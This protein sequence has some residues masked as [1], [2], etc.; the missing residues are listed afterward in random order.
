MLYDNAL[1]AGIYL[2]VFTAT[3]EPWY[4]EVT[5]STL[6]YV[7]KTMTDPEGGFYSAEDADSEGVEGKFYVWTQ[8]E[9]LEALG[10]ALGSRFCEVYDISKEGNFEDK[11]IPNL[12]RSLTQISKI[13]G[14]DLDELTQ[15]MATARA[16][17][18][19]I[20]AQRIRPL[21][22]DKVLVSW[23]ALM[24]DAMARSG[25]VFNEQRYLEAATTAADFILSTLRLKDGRLR[26]MW[27]QGRG[28][29][30]GFLDDYA[31]LINA[32]ITLYESTFEERWIE[33]ALELVAKMRALFADS[34][35]GGFYFTSD[36]HQ[37][38]F[39]RQTDLMDSS[40]PSGNG[41][42]ATALVRLGKLCGRVDF[43]E[44]ARDIVLRASGLLEQSPMAAGQL[45]IAL[46]LLVGPVT[47]IAILGNR[48]DQNTNF[49]I[50][51]LRS[52]FIPNKV[53][54]FRD[55]VDPLESCHALDPI[56]LGRRMGLVP[57]TVFLCEKFVCQ[58]PIQGKKLALEAWERLQ[59]SP[60]TV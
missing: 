60:P 48:D 54:A 52:R 24:I 59:Q 53:V 36:E 20:R 41:M 8:V 10:S 49:V 5:K 34:E 40:V 58:A 37:Q 6:D 17:L 44:M 38:L 27:R 46:D 32:L 57:P 1:L 15:E 3:N 31:Y 7:L 22:D 28:S 51:A 4:A 2:D 16:L 29:G 11:N 47:E 56:F 50:D 12:P 13:K 45:L 9:I 21:L 25:A 35:R 33:S 19:E 30:D 39:S 18:R 43:V 26:H 55:R 42:A 23:N 14:W